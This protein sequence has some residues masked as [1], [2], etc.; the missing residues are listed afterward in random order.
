MSNQKFVIDLNSLIDDVKTQ[1]VEIVAG[2]A[3]SLLRLVVDGGN[4]LP[5][6]PK[7]TGQAQSN[8]FLEVDGC[9]GKTTTD[10]TKSN[11][12]KAENLAAQ[13][14]ASGKIP[15]Y[16]SIFNNLPYIAH[17]EYGLYPNPPKKPTGKTI[18]GHS[19]QAPQGFFRLAVNR[20]DQA[21]NQASKESKK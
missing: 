20:F 13:V 1:Q 3:K 5:G 6:T 16:F 7:D 15:K 2:A 14:V 12:A 9:S 10:T 19:T 17:L 4:G 21:V 18:N 11:L 8:W